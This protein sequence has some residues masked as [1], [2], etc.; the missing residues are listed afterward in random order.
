MVAWC[1]QRGG[2]GGGGGSMVVVTSL[3]AAA[4]AWWKHKFS[5]IAAVRLEVRRN[6][7]GGSGDY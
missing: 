1:W 6:C 3:A 7:G 5:G 4:V 2:R